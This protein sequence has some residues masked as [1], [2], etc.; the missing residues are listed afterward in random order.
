MAGSKG[1]RDSCALQQACYKALQI[2][3]SG[4]FSW[5]ARGSY[6]CVKTSRMWWEPFSLQP[7][8]GIEPELL[9]PSFI[10]SEFSSL[11]HWVVMY[12]RNKSS[13]SQE[14]S[15]LIWFL[16]AV[17]GLIMLMQTQKA[18]IP[19]AIPS[20]T[21]WREAGNMNYRLWFIHPFAAVVSLFRRMKRRDWQESAWD[22]W[23][24]WV[25]GMNMS[26]PHAGLNEQLTQLNSPTASFFQE[27]CRCFNWQLKGVRREL[28]SHRSLQTIVSLKL[29]ANKWHVSQEN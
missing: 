17:H 23:P 4:Y 5:E 1:H 15:I 9:T 24:L 14:E 28:Y 21:R 11:W 8:Q 3:L 27:H 10:P 2:L 25:L 12:P 6:I 29:S 16:L 22:L 13:R 7:S 18:G 20:F 26:P 19:A